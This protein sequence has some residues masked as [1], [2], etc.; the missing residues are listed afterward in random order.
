[1]FQHGVGVEFVRF[2]PE[3]HTPV[4]SNVFCELGVCE[5]IVSITAREQSGGYRKF[6]VDDG[7]RVKYDF[8]LFSA[9]IH[10]YTVEN[11]NEINADPPSLLLSRK[12]DFFYYFNN[13]SFL[14]CERGEGSCLFQCF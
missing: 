10:A 1:M 13:N 14:D 2:L 4:L 3:T 7:L 12:I 8:T 11:R 9:T 6:S 5:N